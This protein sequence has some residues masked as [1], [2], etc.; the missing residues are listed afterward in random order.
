MANYGKRAHLIDEFYQLIAVAKSSI[1]NQLIGYNP[2]STVVAERCKA[3]PSDR[4]C[5][6]FKALYVLGS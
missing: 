4:D 6:D 2:Y 5:R 3:F 1:L